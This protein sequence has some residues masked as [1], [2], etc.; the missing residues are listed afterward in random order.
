MPVKGNT[1]LEKCRADPLNDRAPELLV[2]ET[3]V[4]DPPAILHD[5]VLEKLDEAG[6][7]VHLD[8]GELD[9]VGEGEA[10][11]T[12]HVVACHRQL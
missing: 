1:L 10:L 2:H 3:R 5:P 7:D 11:V 8:V 12:G 4:D 9:S 6:L